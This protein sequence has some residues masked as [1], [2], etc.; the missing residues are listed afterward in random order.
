MIKEKSYSSKSKY[1]YTLTDTYKDDIRYLLT[2]NNLTPKFE[3]IL[4]SLIEKF[5]TIQL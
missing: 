2:N 5:Y 4:K 1:H 3:Y